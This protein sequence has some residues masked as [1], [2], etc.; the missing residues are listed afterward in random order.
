GGRSSCGRAIL[1]AEPAR[2]SMLPGRSRLREIAEQGEGSLDAVPYAV[3][4]VAIAL[5]RRNVLAVLRRRKTEKQ[6]NFADGVPVDCTSH[7]LNETCGRSLVGQGR[8][9]E[10]D[11][12]LAY[13]HA[14]MRR[15][16]LGEALVERGLFER[17]ELMRLLQ[18]SLARKLLDPFSWK[19]GTYQLI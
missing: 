1:A 6:I 7:R 2:V 19:E 18:Q 12:S 3:L 15:L 5:S 11:F 4:L 9:T 10:E 8:L 17:D 13:A 14:T 16:R